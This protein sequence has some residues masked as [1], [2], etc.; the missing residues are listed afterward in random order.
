MDELE[1]LKRENLH[2]RCVMVEAAKE[3]AAFWDCHVAE[4]GLGPH[5]LLARLRGDLPITDVENPYPHL[6]E[7]VR[8][9]GK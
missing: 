9:N 1:R 5:L 7:E 2:L 6:A 3:L 8:S 4:G